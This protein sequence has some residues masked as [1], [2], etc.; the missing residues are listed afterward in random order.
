MAVD[1]EFLRTQFTEAVPFSRHAGVEIIEIA[2][3]FA[4]T[5]L[6]Q[7]EVLSNHI[8]SIHAGAIF[9]LAEAASGAAMIG[10]FADMATAIRPL[11]TEAKICYMKL[12]RGVIAA[13]ARTDVA[14]TLLRAQLA[15]SGLITFQVGVDVHDGRERVIARVAVEWRVTM[16]KVTA[17]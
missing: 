14:G 6:T 1:F 12:G 17:C 5:R 16:P 9:T 13:Q 7:S 2:D 11:A 3:G 4:R 8:G 10:A 15:A